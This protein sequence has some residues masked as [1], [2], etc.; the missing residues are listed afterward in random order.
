MKNRVKYTV[1]KVLT[2]AFYQMPKFLF[3]D[4]F[5]NL[6]NDARVLYML[7]KDRHEL[8]IKNK[9]FNDKREVFL[10]MTREEMEA[11][12]NLSLPTIIKAIKDLK[13]VN[14]IEEE[15]RGQ[16][17]PN[18]LYLL[19]VKNFAVKTVKNLRLRP[20]NSLGQD[21]KNFYPINTNRNKTDLSDNDLINLSPDP[22]D[23]FESGVP[24]RLMDITPDIIDRITNDLSIDSLI[25][26]YPTKENNLIELQAIIIEVLKSNKKEYKISGENIL[27]ED[28]KRTFLELN[29]THLEY[30]L[31]SLK[32]TDTQ[33][34]SMKNYLIKTLYNAPKTID[35]YYTQQAKHDMNNWTF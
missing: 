6:S 5:A 26:R 28:L 24:E 27:A 10:I 17:K 4:E 3:T 31:A 19:E 12:L 11:T 9:W 16:G 35:S 2:N 13:K 8:S 7:L 14:L 22:V 20:K 21:L 34:K 23:N 18:L 15:R 25:S 29:S 1:E 33:I 30:I 32:N